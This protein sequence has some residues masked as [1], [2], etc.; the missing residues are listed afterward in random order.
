MYILELMIQGGEQSHE[1]FTIVETLIVLTVTAILA[2]SALL[3]ISGKQNRTQF[4]V[5]VNSTQQNIE[6]VLNET[7][8]GFFPNEGTVKCTG[9]PGSVPTLTNASSNQGSNA[10]CVFLGKALLFAVPGS[11]FDKFITYPIAGDQFDTSSQPV[12]VLSDAFP[13]AVAPSSTNSLTSG[14]EQTT[15]IVNGLSVYYMHYLS[16]SN[17]NQAATDIG[18]FAYLSDPGATQGGAVSGSQQFALYA[19]QNTGSW[20]P[21][22]ALPLPVNAVDGLNNFNNY[23][24]ASEVDLCLNDGGAR[25]ALIQVGDASNGSQVAVTQHVFASGDCT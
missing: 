16:R 21:A 1:G 2:V 14:L 22:T 9:V 25:S 15:P 24:T 10:G 12:S 17:P 13:E 8:S 19:I 18:A 11:H 6:Q 7:S 4:T 5:A 23:D 20:T 3:L